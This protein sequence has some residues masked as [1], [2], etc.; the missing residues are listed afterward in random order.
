MALVLFFW[1]VG[2]GFETGPH[3]A[4]IA[5]AL[6]VLQCAA[7][8]PNSGCPVPRP[9]GLGQP[10]WTAPQRRSAGDAVIAPDIR[11]HA[12]HI[13]GPE[14]LRRAELPNEPR[15]SWL[16]WTRQDPE[17]TPLANPLPMDLLGGGGVPAGA[18]PGHID[19]LCGPGQTGPGLPWADVDRGC[20]SAERPIKDRLSPP[21][22][23]TPTPPPPPQS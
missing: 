6:H 7:L 14:A 11:G 5:E 12:E 18:A 23:P 3:Q 8:I 2:G 20:P 9:S 17:G 13:P 1:G 4:G 16:P 21:L 22:A 15:A 10:P 19:R